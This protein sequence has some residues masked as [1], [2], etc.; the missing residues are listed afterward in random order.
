LDTKAG[1]AAG[2][3]GK[4]SKIPGYHGGVMGYSIRMYPQQYDIWMICGSVLSKC[5][6]AR[7]S[8][9]AFKGNFTV[10]GNPGFYP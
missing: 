3:L 10:T 5:G 4:P 2:V 9:D 6:I 8:V 7:M 1:L